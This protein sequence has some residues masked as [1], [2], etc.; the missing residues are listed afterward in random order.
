M[1]GEQWVGLAV[2]GAGEQDPGGPHAKDRG[3]GPRLRLLPATQSPP[4]PPSSLIASAAPPACH[5]LECPEG[6]AQDVI[7]TIG[8]AF[9][10][11]FKQY[12]RNPPRLVTPHDRCVGEAGGGWAASSRGPQTRTGKGG[13]LF[14][15]SSSEKGREGNNLSASASCYS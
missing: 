13:L 2:Q 5:I 15:H 6:L 1:N 3:R 11:R 14:P 12:L 8:Q 9:E 4:P 10:L 7:S